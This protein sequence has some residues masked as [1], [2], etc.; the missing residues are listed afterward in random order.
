M[1]VSEYYADL[2]LDRVFGGGATPIPI[3][4]H[5]VALSTTTPN[6]DGTNF[7]EPGFGYA[8]QSVTATSF[9]A[10]AADTATSQSIVNYL[11]SGGAWGTVT[12]F[13]LFDAVSGGNML[14]FLPLDHAELIQDGD[15]GSFPAGD[16]QLNI[17][18]DPFTDL[19]VGELIDDVADQGVTYA[20]NATMQM[21]LATATPTTAGS[22]VEPVGGAYGRST[23]ANNATNWS[24]AA[25]GVKLNADAFPF[26]EAT[27]AWGTITH[28]GLF[29]GSGGPL[30]AFGPLTAPQAIVAGDRP[31]FPPG[32]IAIGMT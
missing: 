2:I 5:Y 26:P 3:A 15:D 10:T 12:H 20:P 31:K 25:A 32:A 7:T 22:F 27:S 4:T 28:W 18:A 9:W 21:G 24:A 30:V 8:R 1:G 14:W 16:L 23:F 17:T 11:A 19:L 13:G 29:D 6:P